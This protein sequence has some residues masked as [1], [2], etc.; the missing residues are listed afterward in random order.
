[1][2][3][4]KS[5][6]VRRDDE[7]DR[8]LRAQRISYD[9]G[10]NEDCLRRRAIVTNEMHWTVVVRRWG[11]DNT[12][13]NCIRLG[14]DWLTSSND[15]ALKNHIFRVKILD[16]YLCNAFYI[17]FNFCKSTVWTMRHLDNCGSKV[18]NWRLLFRQ[19]HRHNPVQ[20][21]LRPR[22]FFILKIASPNSFIG[23][24]WLVNVKSFGD[25]HDHSRFAAC[26]QCQYKTPTHCT[27]VWKA[28]LASF[29]PPR[30]LNSQ[31]CH[32]IPIPLYP[33]CG[34]PIA[35]W[36]RAFESEQRVFHS[37]DRRTKPVVFRR[38]TND[39]QNGGRTQPNRIPF[40]KRTWS[41]RI[42][43]G[44]KVNES[45]HGFCHC[46]PTAARRRRAA[47]SGNPHAAGLRACHAGPGV[48]AV[49]HDQA[50]QLAHHAHHVRPCRRHV[51]NRDD[52]QE[53]ADR[54]EIRDSFFSKHCPFTLPILNVSPNLRSF[55]DRASCA[56]STNPLEIPPKCVGRAPRLRVR[57]APARAVRRPHPEAGVLGR[58]PVCARP[59]RHGVPVL[60]ARRR[61]ALRDARRRPLRLQPGHV[62][63]ARR[64]LVH[65]PVLRQARRE[66][67]PCPRAAWKPFGACVGR[68]PARRLGVRSTLPLCKLALTWSLLALRCVATHPQDSLEWTNNSLFTQDLIEE[69]NTYFK[70]YLQ[71]I[72]ISSLYQISTRK[73]KWKIDSFAPYCAIGF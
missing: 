25:L 69:I 64:A 31:N 62:L 55:R 56:R 38:L 66:C 22:L 9:A 65:V 68:K 29:P 57:R 51:S 43:V 45:H 52:V 70:K 11:V 63:P 19:R 40:G 13:S 12:A 44:G 67:P 14:C 7:R 35:A 26:S 27:D 10:E 50:A 4:C 2:Y 71:Y 39:L 1:M 58:A 21:L 42:W 16:K 72:T 34:R 18:T 60:R 32:S 46:V 5:V 36:V 24:T 6:T 61:R 15:C 28:V 20:C 54:S 41:H 37:A 23:P 48:R 33:K 73:F 53:A 3:T 30:H 8:K 49:R 47:A 17:L 59:P